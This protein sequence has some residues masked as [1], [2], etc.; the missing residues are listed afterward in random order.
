MPTTK[1]SSPG[2]SVILPHLGS[3]ATLM[4]GLQYVSPDR[5]RLYIARASVETT[6][7]LVANLFQCVH[8]QT[9]API[10]KCHTPH[11]KIFFKLILLTVTSV[12]LFDCY[13]CPCWANGT[14]SCHEGLARSIHGLISS[15][16]KV[17]LRY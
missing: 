13:H 17:G 6:Y 1:G 15:S 9:Y 7:K 14:S 12:I 11:A 10:K 16:L 5:P 8:N 3:L 4:V 2:V